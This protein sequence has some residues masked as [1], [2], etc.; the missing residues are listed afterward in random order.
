MKTDASIITE[1]TKIAV[2]FE[3]DAEKVDSSGP[4]NRHLRLNIS[5]LGR[6]GFYGAGIP[7]AYGGL[8]LSGDAIQQCHAL[9]AAA[10]GATAFTQQQ[11]HSGGGYV[12]GA[13]SEPL[14]QELL[15]RFADGS[16]LCGIA[17]S[18]LRRPGK[19]MVTAERV[20]GGWL[21]NG[22]AP[23]VTGWRFLDAFVLGATHLPDGH[24]VYFYVPIAEY[25]DRVVP[26]QPIKLATMDA[27]DTVRV[28]ILSLVLPNKFCLFE[29][30]ADS[31]KRADYCGITG[32]VWLPLG[33]ALG[34]IRQLR[35][36]GEA[37]LNEAAIAAAE[38]L[39]VQAAQI[40]ADANVWTADRADE[41]DYRRNALK[42]RAGAID[43]AM[44]A[45][46]ATIAATGGSAHL[47]DSAAQRRLREAS[48][49]ITVAQT[50]DVRSAVLE[51]TSRG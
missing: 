9:I 11:L 50:P 17:F 44:R 48:F 32:H 3:Y 10:C 47:H 21:I 2:D 39:A 24:L 31:M 25:P 5:R 51:E 37:N 49:Y 18:H 43:L 29:R 13:S 42:T 20:Q 22:T 40:K 19:P 14:K 34:S 35:H 45:A 1:I 41:P 38:R 33:C 7:E 8:A 12:S 4:G 30:E 16:L 26:S 6:L 23:W 46:Q 15:P 27:C 36:I 28:E